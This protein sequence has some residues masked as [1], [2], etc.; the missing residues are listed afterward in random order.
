MTDENYTHVEILVDRS[1]SMS[2][3]A[4]DMVGGLKHLITEQREI[5]GKMTISYSMFDGGGYSVNDHLIVE[6]VFAFLD[7]HDESILEKVVLTPRG[8][9]PLYDAQGQ[10]INSLGQKLRNMPDAV[11][12]AKVLFVTITDGGE[13]ASREFTAPTVKALVETQKSKYDWQFLYLGANQNAFAVGSQIGINDSYNWAAT[14]VGTR[15]VMDSFSSSLSTYAG[16]SVGT[17]FNYEES[18]SSNS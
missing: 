9:T 1:G 13:N 6:S 3:I 14:P 17:A 16:A 8:N 4:S 11:R 2:S 5:P 10:A 7:I 18:D 15:A 12:P